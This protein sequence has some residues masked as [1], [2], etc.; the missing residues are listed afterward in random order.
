MAKVKNGVSFEFNIVFIFPN[1]DRILFIIHFKITL[2]EQESYKGK[3]VE[4]TTDCGNLSSFDLG[5]TVSSIT[6]IGG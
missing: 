5:A 6:V 3:S 2:Y 4:L 1:Y